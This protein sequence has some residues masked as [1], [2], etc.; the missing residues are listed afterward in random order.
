MQ[1]RS[2]ENFI[3]KYSLGGEIESVKI[4]SDDTSMNVSFISD[5]KT[6]LCT[7]SADNGNFPNGEF[8]IYTTSQL[9]SLLV[10]WN[11]LLTSIQLMRTSSFLIKT[12][13]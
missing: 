13:Q 4:E 3:S 11:H 8:G 10:Y 7:V 1:K 5:D 2:I 6:L 9:K 12:H